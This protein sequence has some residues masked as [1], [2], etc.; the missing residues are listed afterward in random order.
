MFAPNQRVCL[1]YRL[2]QGSY[3][4][5]LYVNY[6]LQPSSATFI[7]QLLLPHPCICHI[8]LQSWTCLYCSTYK[9]V[10]MLTIKSSRS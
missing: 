7:T 4:T 1:V 3:W 5:L 9:C 6:F 10:D 8:Q 2:S